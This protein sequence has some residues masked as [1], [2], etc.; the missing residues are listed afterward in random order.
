M[1]WPVPLLLAYLLLALEAPLREAVRI[2][3]PGASPSLVFPLIVFIALLAPAGAALWA[4]LLIGL[5]IDL[6]TLRGA[7]AVVVAGPHALAYLAAAYLVI[8]V[9]PMVM[10]RNPLVLAV[11]S[12]AGLLLA[13]VIV[14]F[15]F[16][17]RRTLFFGTWADDMAGSLTADL[18]HRMLGALLT[19][20]SALVLSAVFFLLQKHFGFQD[21]A[22]RRPFSKKY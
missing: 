5:A 3:A 16:A 4:A 17:L 14:V 13:S 1:K 6:T 9:R 19:G 12:M 2:G 18:W 8:T 15:V 20:I 10:R 22:I 11:L 21:A 7:S